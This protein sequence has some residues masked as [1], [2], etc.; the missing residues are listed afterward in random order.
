M[1]IVLYMKGFER[2]FG[3]ANWEE[4]RRV[5]RVTQ[6]IADVVMRQ[7]WFRGDVL[8]HR[9]S[10]LQTLENGARRVILDIMAKNVYRPFNRYKLEEELKTEA[11]KFLPE[12]VKVAVL[13]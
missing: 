8:Y 3:R 11:K 5:N 13:S 10:D 12:E 2:Y 6:A 4:R 9:I 1:Q 7:D